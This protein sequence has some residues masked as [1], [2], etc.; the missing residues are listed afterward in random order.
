MQR[1]RF[2]SSSGLS[3]KDVH[4]GTRCFFIPDYY[5][6][7]YNVSLITLEKHLTSVL[8]VTFTFMELSLMSL[9]AFAG[10]GLLCLLGKYTNKQIP[11]RITWKRFLISERSGDVTRSLSG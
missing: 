1:A 9:F 3:V 4:L 7:Q 8:T 2:S 10:S 11:G 5:H 6:T